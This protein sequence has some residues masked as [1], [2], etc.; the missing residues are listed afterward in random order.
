MV[1]ALLR[2]LDP[3]THPVVDPAE[4]SDATTDSCPAYNDQR[5]Q[6]IYVTSHRSVN[7]SH[8]GRYL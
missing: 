3:D 1:S 5:Q 2:L 8:D 7:A 4:N 6:E